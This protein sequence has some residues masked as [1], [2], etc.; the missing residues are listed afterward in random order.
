MERRIGKDLTRG[1]TAAVL[2]LVILVLVVFSARAYKNTVDL[3]NGNDRLRSMLS[4]AVTAVNSDRADTVTLEDRDGIQVLC[5]RDKEAGSERR[6]FF[7]DGRVFEDSGMIG[8][9]IY[10]ED[11]SEIGEAERF[12]FVQVSEELI[13]IDTD[14][15]STYI[16][17]HR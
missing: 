3:Q 6:I 5:I 10:P 4:Y 8:S 14:L 13:R 9:K 1:L 17:T 7:L 11:A 16:H 15:G 12:E 2:F